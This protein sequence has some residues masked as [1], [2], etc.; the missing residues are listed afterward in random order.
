MNQ[1]ESK[2]SVATSRFNVFLGKIGWWLFVLFLLGIVPFQRYLLRIKSLNLPQ[3][4]RFIDEIVV[5]IICLIGLSHWRV[6]RTLPK[7]AVLIIISLGL[8]ILLGLASGI[9][10]ANPLYITILGTFDYVKN[11]LVIPVLAYLVI[12]K[13]RFIRLYEILSYLAV[14]LCIIAIVQEIAFFIGI[15]LEWTGALR[16]K[17]R[18]GLARTPSLIG[19]PN[20]FGLY[21]LL[22]F[23]L[24]TSIHKRVRWQNILLVIGVILSVSRMVWLAFFLT[25]IITLVLSR[26]RVAILWSALGLLMMLISFSSFYKTTTTEMVTRPDNYFRGYVLKKSTEVWSHSPIVGIGPGRFGGIVSLMLGSPIYEKINFNP[27]WY[28]YMKGFRS[29]DQ[30]WPQILA[31]TGIL[32]ILGFCLLLFSLWWVPYKLS[33]ATSD[34]FQKNILFGLSLA[35]VVMAVYFIGSGLNILAF[36]FTYTSLLGLV[37]GMRD[38]P[39]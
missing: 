7:K 19:H 11:F 21:A 30:F 2:T 4:F 13:E 14:F 22:F 15:P 27:G 38:E 28:N 23:I 34:S 36:L 3:G 18:L 33:K 8:I 16:T 39:R 32:G 6:K 29:L 25:G 20:A 17:L 37:I 12:K 5:V 35:P 31:E 9:Y 10:N 26:S 1:T 24:D